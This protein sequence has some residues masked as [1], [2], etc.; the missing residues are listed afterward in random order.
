M[1]GIIVDNRPGILTGAMA[2]AALLVCG[3]G[4]LAQNP[5]DI[6]TPVLNMRTQAE[7]VDHQ[8][9]ISGGAAVGV[10][11]YDDKDVVAVDSVYALI[12]APGAN[13]LEMQLATVDGRYL[14]VFDYEQDEPLSGWVHLNLSLT[15]PEILENYTASEVALLVSNADSPIVYPARWGNSAETDTIRIY[16][17]TEGAT[18]YFPTF[19]LAQQKMVAR[20]CERVSGKTAFKFDRACNVPTSDIGENNLVSISR[21]RGASFGRPIEV[22]VKYARHE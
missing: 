17:N 6:A 18:T 14:A 2:L 3:N 9:R 4:P 21:K 12:S 13:H 19:D 22:T 1:V 5:Q 7:F 20:M 16:V 8:E 11:F 15:R 10:A